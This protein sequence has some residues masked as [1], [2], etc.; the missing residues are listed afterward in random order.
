MIVLNYVLYTTAHKN[1]RKMLLANGFQTPTI[2]FI[3]VVYYSFLRI[4]E[5][6][7][8]VLNWTYFNQN[9]ILKI[10]IG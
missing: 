5:Q 2:N 3:E 6:W 1:K 10:C 9:A 7:E 4:L 8:T